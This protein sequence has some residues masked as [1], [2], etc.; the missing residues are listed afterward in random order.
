MMIQFLL[1]AIMFTMCSC[2]K[3]KHDVQNSYRMLT[4]GKY[5]DCEAYAMNFKNGND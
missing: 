1:I 3:A 4:V 5:K 2:K